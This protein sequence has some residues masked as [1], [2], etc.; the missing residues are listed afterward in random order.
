MSNEHG[1][2]LAVGLPPLEPTIQKFIDDLNA[3]G[4]KPLYQLGPAAAHQVLTD[5]QSQPVRLLP[6]DIEDTTF[7]VGPTGTT[8][9]R[10]VPRAR[11]AFFRW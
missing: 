8:R 10:I 3:A 11:R 1:S 4:G 7:P 5:L 6:V 2:A 9:I